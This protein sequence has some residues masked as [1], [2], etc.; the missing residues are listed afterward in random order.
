[1]RELRELQKIPMSLPQLAKH[2]GVDLFDLNNFIYSH[3]GRVGTYPVDGKRSR[4]PVSKK[5]K[6]IVFPSPLSLANKLKHKS[7][8]KIAFEEGIPYDTLRRYI[9][10]LGL[11]VKIG[12]NF[13]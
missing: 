11:K 12:G 13:Y 6:D 5:S 4:A 7:I 8:S 1:M 2:Y 10:K 9:H 3:T